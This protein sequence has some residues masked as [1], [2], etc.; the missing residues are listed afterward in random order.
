MSRSRPALGLVA[1]IAVVAAACGTGSAAP[2]T[3]PATAARGGPPT[4]APTTTST[5]ALPAGWTPVTT[6][7]TVVVVSRR[8]ETESDGHTVTLFR[9]RT[10]RVRFALHAGSLDPPGAATLAGPDAG[11]T[12]GATE[13]ALLVAAFNGGFKANAGVGGFEIDGRVVVPLQAGRASLVIDQDGTARVGLWDQGLPLQG[14]PVASVRQN[15]LPLVVGGQ[16]SPAASAVAPWGSTFKGESA[17][18]RSSLGEDAAGNLVYAAGMEVLPADLASALV[19]AG[20]TTAMQLDINPEW[21]Q[22]VTATTPGAPLVIGVPG[23]HRPSDQYRMGWTRDFITVLA[24]PS[25]DRQAR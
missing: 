16:P 4:S 17:V 10:D 2:T 5:T 9:F 24:K 13:S 18:A 7:G 6:V 1:L 3:V 14:E 21:V 22:L 12:I 20:A 8:T 25:S 23:Q 11:P 19:G 15:L